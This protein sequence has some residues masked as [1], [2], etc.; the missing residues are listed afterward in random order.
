MSE[1]NIDLEVYRAFA[2]SKPTEFDAFLRQW[3]IDHPEEQ[4]TV[5]VNEAQAS[6]SVTVLPEGKSDKKTRKSRFTF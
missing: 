3:C 2:Q 4:S 5:M 1:K 6:P